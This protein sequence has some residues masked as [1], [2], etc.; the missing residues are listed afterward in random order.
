MNPLQRERSQN[1]GDP[2][3]HLNHSKASVIFFFFGFNE[4][5][6]GNQ[7]I[8]K[9][10][11]D[12]KRL[13]SETKKKSYDGKSAPRMVLVSPIAFE[14]TGDK[15]L[16]DGEIQNGNLEMYTSAMK[17][18]ATETGVA[19][20]DLFHPTKVLFEK[21]D[22][23]MTLNGAHLN[24]AGYK[25][26]APIFLQQ[27]TGKKVEPEFDRLIRKEIADKNFHWWHRYRSVNGFSI[28]GARGLAGKDGSNT[29]NN[30]DVMERERAILDQMTANRDARIWAIGGGREVPAAIDDSN[31][32]PFFEPTTNVG[33]AND[34][35][36]KRGKLGSLDYLSAD[37]Q[38]KLFKLPDGYKISVVATEEE[39]PELANP[40][41]INFDK[42]G[43]LWVAT[44]PSYPHWKPK[45]KMDDKVII[46]KDKNRDGRMDDCVV[47]A[48][49]LH[50]P[51]GFEIGYGGRVYCAAT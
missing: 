44:M 37:E 30:R 11:S 25:A 17:G 48:D 8:A 39:I 26:L 27:L 28:Y 29:Y 42:H 12:L 18:I 31:T 16:P 21:S 10:K 19:F 20:V 47:F 46:L 35:N 34:P 45:T 13:I 41:A 9:F 22:V 40:V 14:N 36:R 7:G 6:A 32:L 43:Q 50:Q 51:T 49:G 23:R 1:F 5:F 33:G 24:A 4:S 38:Q 2:D 15:N 3:V